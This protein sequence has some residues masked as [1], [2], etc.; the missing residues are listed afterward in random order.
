[1]VRCVSLLAVLYTTVVAMPHFIAVLS[2]T[3]AL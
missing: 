3:S 1:M 2:L